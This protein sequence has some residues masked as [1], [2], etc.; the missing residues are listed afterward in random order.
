MVGSDILAG[1]TIVFIYI[2]YLGNKTLYV[3]FIQHLCLV[4]DNMY[5]FLEIYSL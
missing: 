2:S 5:C 1:Y 3:L 4:V